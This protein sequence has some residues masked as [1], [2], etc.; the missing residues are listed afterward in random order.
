MQNVYQKMSD[1]ELDAALAALSHEVD[2]VRAKGLAL[3][4]ARGKPSPAQVDISRPMLD[5][6]NSASDLHDGN[7]NVRPHAICDHRPLQK[8]AWSTS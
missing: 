1:S 7:A 6:L 8:R 5:I 3:D 2:E 4:L